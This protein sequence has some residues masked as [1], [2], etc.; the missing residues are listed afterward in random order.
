VGARYLEVGERVSRTD[1]IL[2]LI[3]TG[4]LYAMITLGEEEALRLRKG[5]EALVKVDG[6][7]G[8]YKGIVDLVA[9]QADSQTFTFTVRILLSG[10]EVRENLKPGMFARVSVNAGPGRRCIVIPQ[11][12][13]AKGGGGEGRVFAIVRGRT[14]ER[15]VELGPELPGGGREILSGLTQGDVIALKSASLR[16]GMRV[17]VR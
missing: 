8:T 5:M 9:P 10:A 11:T 1:K 12:A 7:G 15:R 6:S 2:T 16:E 17:A 13:L 14:F 3:D 4:S